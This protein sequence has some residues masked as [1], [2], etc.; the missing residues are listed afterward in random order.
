MDVATIWTTRWSPSVWTGAMRLMI[1]LG[2]QV[3]ALDMP[4]EIGGTIES[5]ARSKGWTVPVFEY[6]PGQW[7]VF[8]TPDRPVA[9][10][11]RRGLRQAGVTALDT[12]TLELPMPGANSPYWHRHLHSVR[13][14]PSRSQLVSLVLSA[15]TGSRG[16]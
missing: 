5:A 6:R 1:E 4:S 16:E 10:A 15:T 11:E 7:L 14:V 2:R 3:C 8:A 9:E 12:G 13:P